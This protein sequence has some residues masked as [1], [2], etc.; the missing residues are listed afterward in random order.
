[1]SCLCLALDGA[2]LIRPRERAGEARCRG[3]SGSLFSP[4]GLTVERS[5][6]VSD[7]SDNEQI[8]GK[9]GRAR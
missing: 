4:I 6:S 3:I 9:G 7:E 5:S 1:M 8:E 2:A